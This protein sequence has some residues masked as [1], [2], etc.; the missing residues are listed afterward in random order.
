MEHKEP[1]GQKVVNTVEKCAF[2]H[3]LDSVVRQEAGQIRI[4]KSVEE[5][6]NERANGDEK[7]S[8]TVATGFIGLMRTINENPNVLSKTEVLKKIG[9]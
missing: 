2:H 5:G 7:I 8:Q 1:S 4:Q 3:I 6:R 9:D